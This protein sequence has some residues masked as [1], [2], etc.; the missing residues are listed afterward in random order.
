MALSLSPD[1]WGR[2]HDPYGG[3]AD[4]A[5][6]LVRVLHERSFQDDA[7]RL[8][9]ACRYA[10]RLDLRLERRTARLA[11]RDAGF[12]MTVGPDRV[13]H[14]L[15]RIFHED[16]PEKA[17][18][19]AQRYGLLTQVH[20]ALTWDRWLAGRFADARWLCGAGPAQERLSLLY[21]GVWLYRLQ[22]GQAAGVLGAL[23]IE[24]R[25][26]ALLESLAALLKAVGRVSPGERPSAVARRLDPF[27]TSAIQVALLAQERGSLHRVLKTYLKE[28]RPTR[29]LLRGDELAA[30]GVPEGPALG[31]ALQA[32]REARLDKRVETRQDEAVLVRRLLRT[33]RLNKREDKHA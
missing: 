31:R 20:P 13:R 15:E 5:A 17:L 28:I 29:P 16:R 26:R 6:G 21:W 19:L 27:D 10:A 8:W 3:W 25:R 11:R 7:T 24:G 33:G 32:L 2:L 30:L 22:A 23:R 9:R 18:A 14:E 12:V 4:L 1:S